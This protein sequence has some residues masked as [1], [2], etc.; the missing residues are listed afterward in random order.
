MK[1]GQKHLIKCRCVLS[2]FKKLE[3]PPQH[4]FVVFSIIEDDVVVQK[5]AQCNN[6]GLIHKILDICTSEIQKNKENM[7]SIMKIEDI[8]PSLH[9]NISNVLE[10]NN[11]DL[12]TWEA[13]QFYTENKLW[14]NYVLM[15][16]DIDGDEIH[17]KYIKIISDSLC[18]V[19]T[20]TR[21]S[22]VI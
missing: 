19:E 18:K 2:Q 4:Q 7:N 16:K 5:Y 20:F 14:G 13:V 22:G 17:G 9:P 3:N 10:H 15:S 1:I 8:K 12:A 21:S 6:C 11:V